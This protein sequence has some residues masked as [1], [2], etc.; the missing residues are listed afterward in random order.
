MKK[1][2]YYKSNMKERNRLKKDGCT[3]IK[4]QKGM[5]VSYINKQGEKIER[6]AS[7]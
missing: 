7:S 4:I 3:K 1:Y 6:G 2:G 5:V